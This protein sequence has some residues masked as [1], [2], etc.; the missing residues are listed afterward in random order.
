MSVSVD[1]N[2]V[3]IKNFLGEKTPRSAKILEGINIKVE[4]FDVIVTGIDLEKV[5]QTAANIESA[6][7]I[8]NRDR[9]VFQDGIYIYKTS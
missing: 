8:T 7:R 1:K 2:R 9:R 5:G 6:C 3:I 4:G